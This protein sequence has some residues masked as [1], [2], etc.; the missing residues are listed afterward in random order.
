MVLLLRAL[1]PQQWERTYNHPERGVARLD[2]TALLY[3]WHSDHH[4][5]HIT[6]L[7]DR[8]GW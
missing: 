3:A 1:S 5:A 7:R 4:L 6:R 8:M 2:K